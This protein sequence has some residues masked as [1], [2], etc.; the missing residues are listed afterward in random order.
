MAQIPDKLINFRA[1]KEGDFIAPA[2]IELP[3]ITSMN[4]TLSGAGIAGEIETPTIGQI[5]S[6]QS[7]INFRTATQAQFDLMAPTGHMLDFR[8]S[9]QVFN[10]ALGKPESMPMRVSMNVLPKSTSLGGFTVGES[11]DS[12]SEMEVT[13]LKIFLDNKE[14]L[15][16]DKLNFIYKINGK[17]YLKEVREDLGMN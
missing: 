2:D 9:L 1:Y 3:E 8:G 12:S 11:M 15:E 4:D 6:M 7:T 14:I 5:E 17:D 13:Y 16:I 10:S